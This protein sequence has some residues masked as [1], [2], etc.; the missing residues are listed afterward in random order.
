MDHGSTVG[1]EEV[2]LPI[3]DGR[4]YDEGEDHVARRIQSDL[5]SAPP[6]HQRLSPRRRGRLLAWLGLAFA[7]VFAYLAFRNVN[8]D[9]LGEALRSQSY[10]W[11]LPSGAAVA[12]GVVLRAWRW[13]LLFEPHARPRLS[14]V[15]T[16]LMIGYL[17]NNVLPA[18]AGE[19]ARVHALGRRT[20]ISRAHVLAT[21]VLERVFDLVVLVAL[22]VVAAPFLPMVDWLTGAIFLGA[23]PAVA[24]V[25]VGFLVRRYGVRF[26]QI[27][28]KPLGWLPRVGHDRTAAI[29]EALVRGLAGITTGRLAL[30]AVAVT[31][32]S[33]LVLACSVWLLLLGTDIEASFGMALLV[34]IATNL[35]L[36][37]P[38]S[39]AAL[40]AFEAA[41]VVALAA[42]GVERA[43]ALSFALVLHALNL[44]PYLVLGYLALALH[45]RATRPQ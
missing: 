28:V 16:A 31:I 41:V 42:Y 10:V 13:Q 27:L 15:T 4:T 34:L 7:L 20:G 17:F 35:V 40:G 19:L 25:V 1:T 9:E 44:F 11:L 26:A 3:S 43:D 21:V 39:P 33:W 6:S 12:L 22:L 14:H 37:V 30:P 36:V 23:V 18:R 24:L 2:V 45:T 38:S 29:A 8:V 32:V 5:D